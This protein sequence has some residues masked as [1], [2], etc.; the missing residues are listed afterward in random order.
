LATFADYAATAILNCRKEKLRREELKK[1]EKS[2]K[3][4]QLKVVL[5][6]IAKA[7]MGDFDQKG[8]LDNI[9]KTTMK[10]LQAEACSIYLA[11][12]ASPN[13]FECIAGAG[14][15]EDIV[16]VAE[17]IEGE[18]LTGTIAKDGIDIIINNKS[19]L[20]KY[21]SKKQWKGKFDN[22][23]WGKNREFKNLIGAPIKIENK[24]IGVIKVENKTGSINLSF[25]EDDL[26]SLRIIGTVIGLTIENVR[27]QN[28]IETQLKSISARAAHRINNQLAN[29]A[30]FEMDL[31]W[32]LND[33]YENKN[34]S[35]KLAE[36]D[37][38][39]KAIHRTTENLKVLVSE[40]Q[41]FGKPI[42]L[43]FQLSDINKIIR[44]ESWYSRPDT[45]KYIIDTK[46]L[47]D[48]IPNILIDSNHFPETIKEII[49]NSIKTFEKYNI[50][51]GIVRFHSK[52]VRQNGKK[53]VFISVDDNGP[54]F[55]EGFPIFDPYKTTNKDSTG[56]GL[57]TVKEVIEKHEG[58][59]YSKKSDALGGARI[60]IYLPI[61]TK[62]K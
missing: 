54:G 21:K 5:D 1:M 38:L 51:N 12:E 26:E 50:R 4:Q 14:F 3:A 31:K 56:L 41:K 62:R 16:G 28:K 48:G 25:N 10:I 59:I 32:A 33:I 13:I 7:V 22:L 17:Y 9:L 37:Y 24:T 42:E 23:Q 36:I 57:A 55:P 43:D 27:L 30:S 18:G 44:D 53:W 20:K 60:E 49:N 15:S 19:E 2:K 34:V 35:E 29:Y 47:D 46:D 40:I 11:K 52:I 6:N 39:C 45:N 58:K 8:V 61:S